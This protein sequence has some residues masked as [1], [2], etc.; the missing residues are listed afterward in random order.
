MCK[1]VLGK[2]YGQTM[3][4]IAVATLIAAITT[5]AVFSV[6]LSSFV[7]QKKADKKELSALALKDAQQTLQAFV[8]ADISNVG[9]CGTGCCAPS[10]GGVWLE[11]GRWA[12]APGLHDIT[13]LITGTALCIGPPAC[14]FTYFVADNNSNT[15]VGGQLG[16]GTNKACKTVTFSMT[17]A[18]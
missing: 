8:S 10:C 3:I 5:V 1:R 16:A 11:P 6:V 9:A 2:R 15:C 4:E 13:S 7:S 12:L 17:F 18:D 14:S